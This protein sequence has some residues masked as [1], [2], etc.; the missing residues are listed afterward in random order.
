MLFPRLIPSMS[1]ISGADGKYKWAPRQSPRVHLKA[2]GG[3]SYLRISSLFT[4]TG[5][6][7][8]INHGANG[9]CIH[10]YAWI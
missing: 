9:L 8:E 6:Y 2:R 3:V 7:I 1:L 10:Y 4:L 5:S